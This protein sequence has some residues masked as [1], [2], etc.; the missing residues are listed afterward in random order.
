MGT[1][2]E[3]RKYGLRIVALSDDFL[4]PTVDVYGWRLDGG[5]RVE[6]PAMLKLGKTY[7]MFAS[8]M[9]G[10]DA[11]ENQYTTSTSLSSGW[12]PWKKF[13]DSGSKV[14]RSSGWS[15]TLRC[16]PPK[17][18]P[19]CGNLNVFTLTLGTDLQFANDI[20]SQDQRE[21]RNLHGR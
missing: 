6:A 21:H 16:A 20:Y 9:T 11:N 14:S 15:H 18:S 17:G 13:A 8:M 12:S 2:D 7:Y 4:T 5:N 10:W 19:H 3:Q 1:D